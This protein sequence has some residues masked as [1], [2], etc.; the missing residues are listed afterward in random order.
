MERPGGRG[1]ADEGKGAEGGVEVVAAGDGGG[2]RAMERPCG[3]GQADE[4]KGAEGG[5]EAF[6]WLSCENL[7]NLDSEC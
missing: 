3:R 6:E 1:Q 5:V 7:D 2:L 4:G